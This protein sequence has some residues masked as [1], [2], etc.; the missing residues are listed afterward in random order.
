[1]QDLT[2]HPFFDSPCIYFFNIFFT[3]ITGKLWNR[4]TT[5]QQQMSVFKDDK[6]QIVLFVT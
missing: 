3:A 5:L 6:K 2:I 1:M 4:K